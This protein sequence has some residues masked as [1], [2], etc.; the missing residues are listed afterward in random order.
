MQVQRIALEEVSIIHISM[1]H[2]ATFFLKK[3]QG[4]QKFGTPLGGS[5]YDTY[6]G[7]KNMSFA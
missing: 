5:V 1:Y 4:M 7:T 6:I 3:V 2:Y